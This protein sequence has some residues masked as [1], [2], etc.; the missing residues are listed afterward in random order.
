M[1]SWKARHLLLSDTQDQLRIG[2]VGTSLANFYLLKAKGR[3]KCLLEFFLELFFMGN[4]SNIPYTPVD[5]G[6]LLLDANLT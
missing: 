6:Q 4:Y 5:Q 1:L 2:L 3:K